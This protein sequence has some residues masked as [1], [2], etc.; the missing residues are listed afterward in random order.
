MSMMTMSTKKVRVRSLASV[1]LSFF[2]DTD[3]FFFRDRPIHG[4][5]RVDV[6]PR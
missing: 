4:Y 5:Q 3:D 1:S 6:L 2:F